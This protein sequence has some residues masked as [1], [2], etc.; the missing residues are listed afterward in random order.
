MKGIASLWRCLL[1]CQPRQFYVSRHADSQ[2]DSTSVVDVTLSRAVL[3]NALAYGAGLAQIYVGHRAISNL[4]L[5]N[6]NLEEGVPRR[7]QSAGNS[8]FVWRPVRD[9]HAHGWHRCD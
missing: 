8:S 4:G 2:M 6:S 1:L 9:N 3:S 7:E 5:E